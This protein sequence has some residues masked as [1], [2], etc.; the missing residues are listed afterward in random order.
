MA[1]RESDIRYDLEIKEEAMA[2]LRRLPE[3]VRRDIGYR[4]HLLQKDFTGDVKKLRGSKNDYR[5]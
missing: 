4:L 3:A 2:A 1:S 5:W